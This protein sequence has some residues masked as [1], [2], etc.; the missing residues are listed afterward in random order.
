[1]KVYIRANAKEMGIA[2]GNTATDMISE[3][4]KNN[5]YANILLATGASQFETLNQLIIRTDVQWDKVTV[6]H[7]DEYIGL[8]SDHKASFRKYLKDRF[9]SKVPYLKASYLI[10]GEEEPEKER[11]RLSD[12]ITAHPIDVALI[13][14]GENC[15]LAFN[16]PPADFDTDEPY[17]IINALDEECR[18]QQVNEGWFDHIS[19]VPVRAIS[20]SVKQVMRSKHIIASVPDLRKA[21]AVKNCLEHT[22]SNVYPASILQNHP[23]CN[24][25]LDEPSASLL[26]DDIS[27]YRNGINERPGS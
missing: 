8:P 1:M 22:V 7:L 20:M 24:L 13:G 4:I 9:L 2:A 21:K 25:Y 6:F 12:I 11:Q 5:G 15:H 16:D 18:R 26:S 19:D 14:I 23:D 10:N 17:I 27:Y 3:T